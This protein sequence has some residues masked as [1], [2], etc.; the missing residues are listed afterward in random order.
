MREAVDVSEAIYHVSMARFL[1]TAAFAGRDNVQR[2]FRVVAFSE[3]P[4]PRL[5]VVLVSAFDIS[6]LI[7]KSGEL[8]VNVIGPKQLA[9]SRPPRAKRPP[10]A[11]EFAEMKA[12][13]IPALKIQAPLVRDCAAYVECAVEQEVVVQDRSLFVCR[14]LA[15]QID[16]AIIPVARIRDRDL[17]LT[18]LSHAP[19]PRH[20]VGIP[21]DTIVSM[22]TYDVA[23]SMVDAAIAHAREKGLAMT[24]AVVDS[25]GTLM[26]LARMEG[27]NFLGPEVARAKAYASA[28]FRLP[29]AEIA[30][31]AEQHPVFYESLSTLTGGKLIAAQGAIPIEIDGRV[32]GAIGASGGKPFIDEEVALAGLAALEG[33]AL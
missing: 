19:G 8:A 24:V 33:S 4:E 9:P 32:V 23:R 26:A 25:S 15:C 14:A 10:V 6:D 1:I 7:R 28:A 11:D 13:K 5:G 31:R 3:E 18:A 12:V 20:H 27:A 29:S 17:D 2:S 16:P 21:P 30:Q 22:L